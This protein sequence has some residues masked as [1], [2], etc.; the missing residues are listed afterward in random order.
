[1]YFVIENNNKFTYPII[2][3]LNQFALCTTANF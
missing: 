2:A 1:M 3:I